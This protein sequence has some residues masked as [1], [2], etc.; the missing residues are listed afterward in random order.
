MTSQIETI[1]RTLRAKRPLNNF[2]NKILYRLLT[3]LTKTI[4][5]RPD[6]YVVQLGLLLTFNRRD[7]VGRLFVNQTHLVIMHLALTSK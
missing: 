6:K 1:L 5:T 4:I 7:R 2:K 3:R